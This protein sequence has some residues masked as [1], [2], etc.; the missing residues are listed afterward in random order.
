VVK[1]E[2]TISNLPTMQL[3][4]LVQFHTSMRK[5]YMHH[6]NKTNDVTRALLS[7]SISYY[8]AFVAPWPFVFLAKSV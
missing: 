1:W 4:H 2:K 8:A 5:M 7:D 6:E 3:V